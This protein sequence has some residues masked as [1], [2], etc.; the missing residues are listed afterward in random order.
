LECGEGRR[1]LLLLVRWAWLERG[2]AGPVAGRHKAVLPPFESDWETWL[3]PKKKKNIYI[4]I[5]LSKYNI[6]HDTIFYRKQMHLT[7]S[8]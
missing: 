2:G 8:Y 7:F 6:K 4:Y 1:L 3:L 5:K